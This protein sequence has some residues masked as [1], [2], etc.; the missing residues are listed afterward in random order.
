MLG[1]MET[2]RRARI[3]RRRS[4]TG[5]DCAGRVTMFVNPDLL[6]SGG[7]ESHRAG[8]HAKNGADQ[9]ARGPVMSGMFGEFAAAD[10]FH[11]ALH[12]A[13]AQH[14]KN[15]QAHQEALGAVGSKAHLA[16]TRFNDMDGRNAAMMRSV[17]CP[18]DT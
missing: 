2:T 1:M 14:V 12:T 6:Q 13:H 9:L 17:R 3:A 5:L 11:D 7:T 10:T 4:D 16:A 18:S 15:L 8:E